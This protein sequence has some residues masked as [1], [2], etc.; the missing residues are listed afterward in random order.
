MTGTRFL[1]WLRTVFGQTATE[2]PEINAEGGESDRTGPRAG[3]ER[4]GPQ[5]ESER[6]GPQTESERPG[7]QT[8]TERPEPRTESERAVKAPLEDVPDVPDDESD[9]TQEP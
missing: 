9:G 3:S 5:T 4:P 1:E 2:G 8:E 7:P 6:P